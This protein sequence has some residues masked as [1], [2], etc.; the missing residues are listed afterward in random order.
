[1]IKAQTNAVTNAANVGLVNVRQLE[2]IYF[3]NFFSN[4]ATICALCSGLS[5]QAV[6]SSQAQDV[7][8]SFVWKYIFYFGGTISTMSG[9]CATLNCLYCSV[10]G[11]GLALRGPPGSM[12]CMHLPRDSILIFRYFIRLFLISIYD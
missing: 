3:S 2:I 6:G 8:C 5:L 1:M 10:Y 7:E 9:L 11:E 12:V 4:F